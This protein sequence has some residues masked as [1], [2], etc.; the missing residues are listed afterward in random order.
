M[1]SFVHNQRFRSL[2]VLLVEELIAGSDFF[3]GNVVEERR[4]A[5][6]DVQSVTHALFL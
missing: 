1:A 3:A 5:D 4:E 6:P 2:V